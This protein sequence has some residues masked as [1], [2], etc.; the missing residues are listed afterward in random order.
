MI[1]GAI[2]LAIS[3]ALLWQM[4]TQDKV[5]AFVWIAL[6]FIL[7]DTI[8]TMTN[9]PYYALTSELT[10]DYDERSSLTTYRF[11]MAVRHT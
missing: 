9:V 11:A 10:E 5:W 6:T 7:F 2:P 3:I 4:P 1:F 8:W